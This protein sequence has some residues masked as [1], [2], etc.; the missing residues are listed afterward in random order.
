M[1]EKKILKL[2]LTPEMFEDIQARSKEM[3]ISMQAFCC[4]IIGEKLHQYKLAEETAKQ[5]LKD[6]AAEL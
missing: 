4:Y 5:I 6:K 3:S 2:T 1:D